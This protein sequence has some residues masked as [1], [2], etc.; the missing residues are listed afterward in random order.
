MKNEKRHRNHSFFGQVRPFGQVGQVAY[1]LLDS[2]A[3]KKVC[4][5]RDP[6]GSILLKTD[7]KFRLPE[8]P[9]GARSRFRRRGRRRRSRFMMLGRRFRRR[10]RRK[11]FCGRRSRSCLRRRSRSGGCCFRRRSRSGRCGLRSRAILRI[12]LLGR[13]VRWRRSAQRHDGT[14]CSDRCNGHFFHE[15]LLLIWGLEI[16]IASQSFFSSRVHHKIILPVV[17]PADC[18]DF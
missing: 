16:I 7:R 13:A 12:R 9:P 6:K 11:R 17:F 3:I 18:A 10:G 2:I 14:D 8:S 5:R 4:F 15:Y 1:S